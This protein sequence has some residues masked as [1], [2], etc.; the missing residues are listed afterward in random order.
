MSDNNKFLNHKDPTSPIRDSVP[1]ILPHLSKL[2]EEEKNTILAA[3]L[4]MNHVPVDIM[5]FLF[6]DYFLGD[7]QITNHGKS[8]FNYWLDKL[9]EIFP[10]PLFD[11]YPY[12][13]FSGSVGSGKSYQ[14]KLIGLYHYHKLDCCTNVFQSLGLA[15]GTKLS[16]GFFHANFE[17]SK[18]DFV[19][20]YKFVFSQSPYFRKLYNR[21]PIRLIPSGPQSTGSVLGTQ[22]LYCVLSELGFWR[23]QDA[24]NKMDECLT[25]YNSRFANKRFWFGGVVADSSAKDSDHGA[26]QR[27]EEIVPPEELFKISPAQWETRPELYEESKGKTFRVYKGDARQ[28]PR[29][30]EDEEDIVAQGMDPDR[31]INVPISAK[32]LF[33]ANPIRNLQDLAGVPYT[34]Q[35]LFFGGDLSHVLQCSSIRN[36]APEIITVDFYNKEDKIVDKV[37]SMLWRI[38]RGTHLMVHYDIGLRK[39]ITGVALCFYSGEKQVGNASLPCFKVPLV[40]GVSRIKGQSTSLDHLYGFIKDLV[41]LGYTITF[42]ADSF[43]SAGLFQS[44]ERDGIDYR[45]I[46]MDKT[47]D[48]GIM[49]KNLINSDRIEMPYHNTFLRECSE[50][51]VVTNGVGNQHIKLDHPVVSNCTDFDYK[52][53]NTSNNLPGT[54]DIFDAV[55]GAVYSAYLKYSEYLENGM[56]AGVG[57]TMKATE[58]IV[59]DARAEVQKTF[60]GMLENL[61]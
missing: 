8:I 54:K 59:K 27:F 34:G 29:V 30:V 7:E 11:P 24:K 28:L 12:I 13:S 21:P 20:F 48:A 15:G 56:A 3:S 35:D 38:P 33:L 5:T 41:K 49:L 1:D 44:L 31:I 47:M 17:T 37:Q 51:K 36:T 10:S 23:P 6:D 4:G 39:D 40:F 58:N 18:K 19:E 43:A 42:S 14:S 46:S 45:S 53:K 26:T 52:D 57:M 22:L 25:R 9:Q 60:Q 50:I 32:H 2:T 16:F 61:F 55:C